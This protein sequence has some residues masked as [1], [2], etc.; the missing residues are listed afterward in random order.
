[1]TD[2]VLH[3]RST[4]GMYGAEQV[5][6][7]IVSIA[8]KCCF[9]THTL[10]IEGLNKEASA[11]R[12]NL[13]SIKGKFDFIRSGRRLDINVIKKI[14]RIASNKVIVHTHDYK[15][16]I[17]ASISLS[18]T[19]TKIV[20]HIHGALGNTVSEKLYS[21]LE[22][23]FMRNADRIITVSNVQKDKIIKYYGLKDKVI[24]I[25]N[26]TPISE[27]IESDYFEKNK[28]TI[29]MAARFTHEKN[30]KKAIDVVNKLRLIN[31]P[32]QLILLGDGPEIENIKKYAIQLEVDSNISFIGFTADV[33]KWLIK[34]DLLLIT[35]YTEGLPMSM[36]EAMSCG[37]PVMSTSVGEIPNILKQSNGG[38]IADSVDAIVKE[39]ENLTKNQRKLKVA[40]DYAYNFSKNNL[41]I[42]TQLKT[43]EGIYKDV[44]K[45]DL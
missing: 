6:F 22:R 38:W 42:E 3:I 1:M 40:G 28:L 13:E 34:S 2:S 25:N 19:N 15:S 35:S 27:R 36:L 21:Y 29:I 9:D 44:T 8:D 33:N 5:V 30:H 10:V 31:M 43:I 4:I 24:Q 20:H 17:L 7:N 26:G 14:R 45:G 11:L 37:I 39:I 23:I 32:V 12:V 41:S 16:L 18:F